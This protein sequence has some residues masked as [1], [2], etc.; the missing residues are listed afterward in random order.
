MNRGRQESRCHGAISEWKK[1]L[2]QMRGNC[3]PVGMSRM[4]WVPRVLFRRTLGEGW[5][6][7]LPI[8]QALLVVG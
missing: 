1:L 3:S 6:E 5:S 7:T 8:L 2:Q 4:R